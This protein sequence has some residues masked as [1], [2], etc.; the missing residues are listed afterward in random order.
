MKL[1]G[2]QRKS[3]G[4]IVLV[5]HFGQSYR[6]PDGLTMADVNIVPIVVPENPDPNIKPVRRVYTEEERIQMVERLE[7]KKKQQKELED[8]ARDNK[9]GFGD[10]VFL[11][12]HSTGFKKYW[13]ENHGG[14]CA[15]CQ[16]RQA[17]WNYFRFAGP[18][19]LKT[20]IKEAKEKDGKRS[21]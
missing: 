21:A 8:F 6:L 10:L 19:F 12:T 4:E 3:D 14:E 9:I 16:E 18:K 13:D 2:V 17:S 1:L 11:F 20:L 7:E 15:P 5:T